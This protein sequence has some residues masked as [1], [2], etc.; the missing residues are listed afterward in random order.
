MVTRKFVVFLIIVAILIAVIWLIP[1]HIAK[2]LAWWIAATWAA[3]LMAGIQES[4]E[5]IRDN[6]EE[7]KKQNDTL[8]KTVGDVVKSIINTGAHLEWRIKCID[9]DRQASE[10]KEKI[11]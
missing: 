8:Q 1:I 5:A 11:E 3:F 6:P 7:S 9:N 2:P 4:L 10:I